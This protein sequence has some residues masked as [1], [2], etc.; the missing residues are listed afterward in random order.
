MIEPVDEFLS[1]EQVG[2]VV[3]VNEKLLLASKEAVADGQTS[4][5]RDGFAELLIKVAMNAVQLLPE[6]THVL[7]S[8]EVG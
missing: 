3:A 2:T 8:L 7:R 6:T 1:V 4:L 5:F